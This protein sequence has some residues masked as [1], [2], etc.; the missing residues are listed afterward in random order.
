M[1]L[2]YIAILLLGYENLDIIHHENQVPA[3]KSFFIQKADISGRQLGL[4]SKLY[5]QK[6]RIEQP[7]KAKKKHKPGEVRPRVGVP[8]GVHA[9]CFQMFF[10][11]LLAS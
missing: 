2:E 8:K 1:R 3:N 6:G 7:F 10:F 11:F 5:Q 9:V 4:G